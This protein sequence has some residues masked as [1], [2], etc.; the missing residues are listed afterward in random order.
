MLAAHRRPTIRRVRDWTPGATVRPPTAPIAARPP[1]PTEPDPW[2]MFREEDIATLVPKT[3]E[4]RAILRSDSDETVPYVRPV[5]E[6]PP[7]SRRAPIASTPD[8]A[9][10]ALIAVY[11]QRAE[12]LAKGRAHA[13]AIVAQA[14]ASEPPTQVQRRLGERMR[15][16]RRVRELIEAHAY[17]IIFSVLCVWGTLHL[18]LVR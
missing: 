15:T 17:T 18:L 8:M 7:S 12:Q 16:R 2:S 4:I 6:P 10:G 11:E 3:S 14:Q 13:L 1:A 9:L 5:V